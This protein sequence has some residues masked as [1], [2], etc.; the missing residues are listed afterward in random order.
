MTDNAF[1]PE[2]IDAAAGTVSVSLTNAGEIAHTF[3]IADL[4]VDETVEPGEEG[5]VEFDAEA[6]TYDVVC[7]FHPDMEATL[8]VSE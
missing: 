4:G 6:G 7:T 8:N 1:S 2:S 3:T 5:T